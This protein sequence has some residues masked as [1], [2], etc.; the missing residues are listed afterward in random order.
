MG[1]R[2]E[3]VK[4]VN[5][6]AVFFGDATQQADIE[7]C[8]APSLP[9]QIKPLESKTPIP[10]DLN[11]MRIKGDGG[12]VKIRANRFRLLLTPQVF[13]AFAC[14]LVTALDRRYKSSVVS[15]WEAEAHL[16]FRQCVDA[17]GAT[18]LHTIT[19]AMFLWYT[20]SRGPS[21]VGLLRTLL[22]FW[23]KEK[24]PG[25]HNSLLYYIQ[26]SAPPTR[27]TTQQ[28]QNQKPDERPLTIAQSRQISERISDLYETKQFDAQQYLLWSLATAE[29]L[30]P[31]QLALLRIK[32]FEILRDDKGTIVE[33]LIH[34]AAVKQR[35]T[36]AHDFLIT[37]TLAPRVWTPLLEQLSFIRRVAG[38]ELD[39]DTRILCVTRD[40]FGDYVV[41]SDPLH[42]NS[43]ISESRNMVVKGIPDLQ[44]I[45]LFCRRFKHT[46]L[47]HLGLQGAPMSTLQRCA[48]QTSA[49]SVR[50]YVN[51]SSDAHQQ[52]EEKM[53]GCH[54]AVLQFFKG[55]IVERAGVTNP[56]EEHLIGAPGLSDEDLGACAIRPC[57][58]LMN[59]ACYGCSKFEAF[60]DGA[61]QEALDQLESSRRDRAALKLDAAVVSRDDH[62]IEAVK[63][64]IADIEAKRNDQLPD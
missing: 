21:Q 1:K 4:L 27:P 41:T 46:M 35:A 26:S 63:Q 38:R 37:E 45:A 48:Y 23:S 6:A 50:R 43:L 51:L 14:L 16:F 61:H 29:G 64:V 36:A 10:V 33:I 19:L 8:R 32:D 25:I 62:L 56:D 34:V 59:V 20:E 54:T 24:L 49:G 28:I 13:D 42:A 40:G 55:R 3:S 44:N 30:R 11:C 5:A 31:S 57:T 47:T 60:L 17:L 18:P 39:P 53:A 9:I 22:L 52:Y 58:G 15:R 2:A 12:T 7:D